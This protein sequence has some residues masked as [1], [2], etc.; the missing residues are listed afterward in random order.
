V[1]DE[2][3]AGD[4][5]TYSQSS[6][7]SPSKYCS[8]RQRR[9][10]LCGE[11]IDDIAPPA[12]PSSV[13]RT[14]SAG[15][16]RSGR[17]CTRSRRRRGE[18]D[19]DSTEESSIG[20]ARARVSPEEEDVEQSNVDSFE[21]TGESLD[22]DTSADVA[23]ATTE[24]GSEDEMDVEHEKESVTETDEESL[25]EDTAVEHTHVRSH[26]HA[27]P[28]EEESPVHEEPSPKAELE[29]VDDAGEDAGNARGMTHQIT[30]LVSAVIVA[31]LATWYYKTYGIPKFGGGDTSAKSGS[32]DEER[33][34]LALETAKDWDDWDDDD[35][36]GD[37][38][39][40]EAPSAARLPPKPSKAQAKKRDAEEVELAR[41]P[42]PSSALSPRANSPKA[43]SPKVISPRSDGGDSFKSFTEQDL[44]E[45]T[46]RAQ[47]PSHSSQPPPR[48]AA[49]SFSEG[50][51]VDEL[52]AAEL[53]ASAQA[54]KEEEAAREAAR[55][56]K[57]A[58]AAERD[59][60]FAD[61]EVSGVSNILGK[62]KEK[63]KEKKEKPRLG[64][65]RIQAAPKESS[66]PTADD[67]TADLE[68]A[69]GAWGD[70][71]DL[72]DLEV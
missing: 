15:R 48:V 52:E 68:E 39:D 16:A 45:E 34:P 67:T 4:E 63:G 33:K 24:P 70:D 27:S 53:A 23:E 18:C 37:G 69:A 7:D 14:T 64:A 66:L 2:E 6:G 62:G 51:D 20:S 3:L 26:N 49:A 11:D 17:P 12:A 10:G 60:L 21:E 65:S 41:M 61:L 5:E 30:L 25:S 8:P 46:V 31:G 22:S 54:V 13:Y 59:A 47:S 71:E 44:T 40:V 1:A 42:K 43:L 57:E 55:R 36:G 72:E 29:Q 58:E 50:F 9:Q 35:D 56:A 38:D 32:T 28:P 19:D